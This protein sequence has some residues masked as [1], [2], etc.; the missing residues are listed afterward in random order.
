MKLKRRLYSS[1]VLPSKLNKAAD[2]YNYL[3]KLGTRQIVGPSS[4]ELNPRFGKTAKVSDIIV[5]AGK[6]AYKKGKRL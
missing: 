2:K 3:F 4:K 5:G 1:Y 6:F